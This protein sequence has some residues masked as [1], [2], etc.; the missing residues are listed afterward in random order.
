VTLPTITLP[1]CQRAVCLSVR[2]GATARCNAAIILA[3]KVMRCIQCSLVVI[4]IVVV[5]IITIRPIRL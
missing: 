1:K 4:I 2:P 3:A 5:I